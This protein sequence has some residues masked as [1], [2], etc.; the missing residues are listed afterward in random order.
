MATGLM[1]AGLIPA[2]NATLATR[3]SVDPYLTRQVCSENLEAR[4]CRGRREF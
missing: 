1:T 3:K 4:L 2:Y